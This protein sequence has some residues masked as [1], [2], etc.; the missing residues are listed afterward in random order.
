MLESLFSYK[1][2]YILPKNYGTKKFWS[3]IIGD[4]KDKAIN[5]FIDDMINY[6]VLVQDDFTEIHGREYRKYE[7][8]VYFKR[9]ILE[10]M[11][12]T[13]EY[14]KLS[15]AFVLLRKGF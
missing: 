11:E 10:L 8:N 15:T 2:P 3:S 14:K 6:K 9:M 13:E 12:K 1:K 5:R 4:Y 7:L